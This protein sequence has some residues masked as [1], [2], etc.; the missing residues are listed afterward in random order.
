LGGFIR[1]STGGEEPGTM[2]YE[3]N[4]PSGICDGYIE[5]FETN[6][7]NNWFDDTSKSLVNHE[8]FHG[9]LYPGEADRYPDSDPSNDPDTAYF[10][11]IMKYTGYD[12]RYSPPE[13]PDTLTPADI[14]GNYIIDEPTYQGMESED[15]IL[16]TTF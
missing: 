14:K 7:T 11:S 6:I 16:G 2:V 13:R 12:T 9:L 5:R 15:K 1:P 3:E 10:N 4:G 8:A